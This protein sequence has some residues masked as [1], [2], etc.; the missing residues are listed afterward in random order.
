[1]Q[2]VT[3]PHGR[4]YLLVDPRGDGTVVRQDILEP[5]L[6]VPQWVLLEF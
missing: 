2:R 3:P 4:P 5:G 1:V 6:R